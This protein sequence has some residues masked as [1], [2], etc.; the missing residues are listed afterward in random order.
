M[1]TP[2]ATVTVLAPSSTATD[3]V[4]VA[5]ADGGVTKVSNPFASTVTV[6]L[7]SAAMA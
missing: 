5:L 4:R 7:A 1:M 6:L 3:T 2:T